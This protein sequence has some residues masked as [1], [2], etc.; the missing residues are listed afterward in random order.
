MINILLLICCKIQN[1]LHVSFYLKR[2]F[3]KEKLPILDQNMYNRSKSFEV[4]F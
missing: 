3:F 4:L 1:F 2:Q